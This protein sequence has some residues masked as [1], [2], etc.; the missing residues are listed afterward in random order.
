MKIVILAGG[1]GTRLWPISRNSFPKQFL[2]FGDEQS[3]LQKTIL[4]FLPK[5]SKKD[6]LIVTSQEYYHLVKNQCKDID[7]EGSIYILIEPEGKNTAPAIILA[8]RFLE[9]TK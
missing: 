6:I 5:V 3:L 2:H 8:L 4:R 7:P 9:E 1:K